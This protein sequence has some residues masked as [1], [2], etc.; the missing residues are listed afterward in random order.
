MKKSLLP[1]IAALCFWLPLSVSSIAQSTE[2]DVAQRQIR[3]QVEFVDVSHEQLTELMFGAKPAANDTELRQQVAQLVKD[4]KAKIM[5]TL[6]CTGRSGQ[7]STTESIEEFIYPTEYEP[8]EILPE[9][10]TEGKEKQEPTKAALPDAVGPTPTAFE[11]RNLGSTLEIEPT[12]SEDGKR[13]D[14]RFVPEIVYHVGN[15]TWAEWKDEHGSCPIQMPTMYTIRL[16]TAVSLANG[17]PLMV[18]ALTPKNEKG[19][20]DHTRKLMVFVKADVLPE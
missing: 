1:S 6:L 11:T 13:I 3:V 10:P 18:G 17:M 5:E 15:E 8:A 20:P 12:A 14:L 9:Q 16:N 19:L 4:G 2:P 7:K